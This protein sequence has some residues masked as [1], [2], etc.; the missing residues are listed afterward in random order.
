MFNRLRETKPSTFAKLIP[1]IGNTTEEGLALPDVERRVLIERVS[2]I[3]HVAASV[4]FDDDLRQAIFMNTRST[5]DICI[6]AAQ[7]KNLIVS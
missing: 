4:R 2:I 5:R 7:M 1:I 6:L 3:F